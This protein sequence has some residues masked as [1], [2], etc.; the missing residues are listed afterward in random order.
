MRA[1]LSALIVTPQSVC[2]CAC[3]GVGLLSVLEFCGPTCAEHRS[4]FSLTGSQCQ[5]VTH[6][7]KGTSL[8]SFRQSFSFANR[9]KIKTVIFFTISKI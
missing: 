5:G 9:M 6:F 7:M 8:F 1:A 3:V 4:V 2:W